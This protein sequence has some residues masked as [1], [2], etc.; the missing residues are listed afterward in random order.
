MVLTLKLLSILSSVTF[1]MLSHPLS[2]GMM[3]LIQSTIIAMISS[4]NHFN[5]WFSYILFLIMVG[6]M[7]VLFIYMTSVASNEKF[8]YSNKN[9]MLTA[10]FMIPVMTTMI[11]PEKLQNFLWSKQDTIMMNET[12]WKMS[13]T[14]FFM[15][16]ASMIMIMLMIYLLVALITIVK[17]T[18]ISHGPL[19]QKF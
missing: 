19:R 4:Q 11:F 17:I 7:L 3:L 5:S 9:M 10:F 6:G 1:V 13:F 8:K 18:N 2:L 15:F 12:M 14:K 16:P